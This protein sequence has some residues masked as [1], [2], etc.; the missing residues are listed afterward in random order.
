MVPPELTG[1]GHLSTGQV[2]KTSS[3]LVLETLPR[4]ADW[5]SE[6]KGLSVI[7]WQVPTNCQV[8][9]AKTNPG[10]RPGFIFTP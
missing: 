2:V 5:Y 6:G 4:K 7:A 8:G 1:A 3:N 9:G 10:T